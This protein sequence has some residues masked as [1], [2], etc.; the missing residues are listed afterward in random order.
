MGKQGGKMQNLKIFLALC[1][2][3]PHQASALDPLGDLQ[4]PSV[5]QLQKAMT[6]S[7]CLS[8]LW[9]GKTRTKILLQLPKGHKTVS[10]LT[11][12]LQNVF[13]QF[14]KP[15][16]FFKF[17]RCKI[18]APQIIFTYPTIFGGPP[19]V[20]QRGVILAQLF[21]PRLSEI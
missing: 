16:H 3:D 12:C 21:L 7:H 14:S 6:L 15:R 10:V 19:D 4:H 1:P 20:L 13:G 8:C 9:H 17:P 11:C 5:P 2:L 18:G